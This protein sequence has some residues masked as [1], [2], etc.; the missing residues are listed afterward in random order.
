MSYNPLKIDRL[1]GASAANV[2]EPSEGDLARVLKA[3]AEL[4]L[5][6]RK[7]A[8]EIEML[9]SS[10]E[11]WLRKYWECEKLS[12]EIVEESIKEITARRYA[13]IAEALEGL[14]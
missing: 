1:N 14:T 10:F 7:Q 4:L 5:L 9:K 6:T 12:T 11:G 3:N 13:E 2:T 8:K